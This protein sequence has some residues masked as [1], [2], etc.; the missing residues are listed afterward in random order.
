MLAPQVTGYEC[1][2]ICSD[3]YS[4]T[5][6]TLLTFA[7]TGPKWGMEHTR[8]TRNT[9]HTHHAR[10]APRRRDTHTRHTR[11]NIHR[12]IHRLWTN[13]IPS[14]ACFQQKHSITALSGDNPAQICG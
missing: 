8:T 10:H 14:G 13:T 9:R 4:C 5:A 1:I 3:E 6:S 7:S 2:T 12:H 11:E